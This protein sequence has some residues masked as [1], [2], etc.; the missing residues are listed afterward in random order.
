V[1]ARLASAQEPAARLAANL[2]LDQVPDYNRSIYSYLGTLGAL[3]QDE[4]RRQYQA[5]L[6]AA[7]RNFDRDR[8][9]AASEP[10]TSD[11]GVPD[12]LIEALRARKA[13]GPQV[14]QGAPP[15]PA[16]APPPT[17][18]YPTDWGWLNAIRQGLGVPTDPLQQSAMARGGATDQHNPPGFIR[19]LKALMA[20]NGYYKGPVN[21]TAGKDLH[22]AILQYQKAHGLSPTSTITAETLAHLQGRRGVPTPPTRPDPIASSVTPSPIPVP[23][24]V[25]PPGARPPSPLDAPRLPVGAATT[26]AG[27]L[28]ATAILIVALLLTTTARYAGANIGA[29]L[30]QQGP[31]PLPPA[32]PPDFSRTVSAGPP[33]GPGAAAAGTMGQEPRRAWGMRGF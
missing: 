5:S 20:K 17:G 1:P 14:T 32:R 4:A 15:P 11:V 16:A 12:P 13:G 19:Y 3:S 33:G 10:V 21:G 24:I 28:G 25:Q 31:V 27:D 26:G 6:H 7:P 2:P 23:S 29:A 30:G 9:N 8:F 22:T 18:R